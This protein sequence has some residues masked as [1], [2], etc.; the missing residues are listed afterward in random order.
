MKLP[1]VLKEGSTIGIV[2]PSGTLKTSDMFAQGIRILHEL[3]FT[4][5]FPGQ[6]WPGND[7][8]ADNDTNRTAELKEI[9]S[10]DT[11]DALMAARGGYGCL[12]LMKKL[13]TSSFFDNPKMFIGFSD[14]TL[15][16][17]KINEHHG[18]VTFHG[19][20]VTSLAKLDIS[21]IQAFKHTLC[22]NVQRWAVEPEAEIIQNGGT[23]RGTTAGGNL[24]TIISTLGTPF[25]PDWR[26]KIVF[27]EDTAE[28]LYRLDK[29]FT[30][31]H[32]AGMLTEVK[33]LI[34]GDFSH[35]LGLDRNNRMRHHE[36]IWSRVQELVDSH[37]TIWGNFPIGHGAKN[38]TLPL[39]L[40][41]AVDSSKK[42]LYCDQKDNM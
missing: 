16:H 42:R 36:A 27:L 40:D 30:Q 10:D 34:L 7:Y 4:T 32:L 26:G 17:S 1:P 28:P 5:R 9:W 8:L 41:I 20:V 39:G 18:L 15:L 23:I 12:R 24:S 37:V 31:L 19:P 14:L 29:M 25:A 35:G 38:I 33:G 22:Q 6:L 21:S 3:G 13:E 11:V 2:A